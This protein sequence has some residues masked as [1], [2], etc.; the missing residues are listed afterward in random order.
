MKKRTDS[1]LMIILLVMVSL[2]AIPSESALAAGEVDFWAVS[3]TTYDVTYDAILKLYLKLINGYQTKNYGRHD[4][5][6]EHM[7]WDASVDITLKEQIACVKREV[8]FYIADINQDGIDELVINGTGGRIYELFTMDNGKV[9][10]L[11]RG[12]GRYDCHLQNDGLFFRHGSG[13]ASHNDYEIWQMNGTGR[14]LFVEGYSQ[15]P[16]NVNLTD[17][18]FH[19]KKPVKESDVTGG[20]RISASA[21]ESWIAKQENKIVRKRFVPFIAYEKF[22]DDPWNLGVLAKDNK[23]STSAKIRIRKEPRDNAKVSMTKKVGTYV[24]VLSK[25]NGYYRIKVGNKEGYVKEEYLIPVTWQD[26]NDPEQEE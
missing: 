3:Y 21:A 23:T 2:A 4:L 22:P 15:R 10:E 19:T 17:A 18:W 8:G 7:F 6:N 20:E 1:I 26:E 13:G 9:R 16:D 12:G 5:F 24:K 25:E 14:V 11:I